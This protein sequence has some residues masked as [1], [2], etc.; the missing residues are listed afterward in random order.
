[1][2]ATLNHRG[3]SVTQLQCASLRRLLGALPLADLPMGRRCPKS[4]AW[5][6]SR[7]TWKV[8]LHGDTSGAPSLTAPGTW[9]PPQKRSRPLVVR[10]VAMACWVG[11]GRQ[12]VDSI[13]Q[14]RPIRRGV[15]PLAARP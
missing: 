5:A 1:M 4:L 15:G 14:V 12:A 8:R 9:A 7:K 2:A 3:L 11:E 10:L 6:D 13:S